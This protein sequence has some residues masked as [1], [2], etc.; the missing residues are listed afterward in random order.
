[1]TTIVAGNLYVLKKITRRGLLR[2]RKCITVDVVN[3]RN[4]TLVTYN[5][6]KCFSPCNE[7][8]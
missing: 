8:L 7:P 3:L 2:N 5:T 1:M 4:T 6:V